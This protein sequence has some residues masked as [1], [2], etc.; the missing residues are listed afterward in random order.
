LA[1]EI[2]LRDAVPLAPR[3][4]AQV[5]ASMKSDLSGGSREFPIRWRVG[6]AWFVG[7]LA[8]V[9][10]IAFTLRALAGASPVFFC[11]FLF[12]AV[13]HQFAVWRVARW[14]VWGPGFIAASFATGFIVIALPLTLAGIWFL[15][16]YVIGLI[17]TPVFAKGFWRWFT[18]WRDIR[19]FEQGKQARPAED[20]GQ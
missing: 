3:P 8:G 17:A 9:L 12:L 6:L 7:L 11:V 4:E 19:N 13:A 16:P 5:P 2:P 15:A 1:D 14:A 10:G 20:D 18:A